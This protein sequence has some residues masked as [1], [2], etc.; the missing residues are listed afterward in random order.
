[1]K[2]GLITSGAVAALAL[3]VSTVAASAATMTETAS[4]NGGA[5]QTTDFNDVLTLAGFDTSLG[6]LTGV[7]ITMSDAG[8]FFGTVT[9]TA[10]NNNSFSIREDVDLSVSGNSVIAGLAN[11]LVETQAYSNVA[12]GSPQGFGTYNPTNSDSVAAV[13]A[14]DI[15]E[16]LNQNI[17]VNVS[18]LTSE[19][20]LGGGGN[21]TASI[22]TTADAT[23]TVTYTYTPSAPPPPVPEP[24]SLAV[25]GMG[26]LGLGFVRTKSNKSV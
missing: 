25:L 13:T 14:S 23:I 3:A 1:M 7:S 15:A 22:N 2:I 12:P 24:A 26:L 11:S 16:F 10:A 20:N 8:T 5:M 9:N 18:T 21:E 6:T 4:T 17:T 19:T